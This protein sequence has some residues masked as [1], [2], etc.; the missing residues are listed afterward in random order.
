MNQVAEGSQLL[1]TTKDCL[2]F[3]TKC[4]EVISVSAPHIYHSAP[5]FRPLSSVVRK[6]YCH[7]CP[8]PCPRVVVGLPDVWDTS[9]AIPSM[10][11]SQGNILTWS[12][13]SQFIAAQAGRAVEICAPLTFELLSTL[14]PTES[15]IALILHANFT[16]FY[17]P[18]RQYL[19]SNPLSTSSRLSRQS[20]N[21][22]RTH[23]FLGHTTNVY[24]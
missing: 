8:N 7:Q 19:L 9:I 13:Y 11:R 5:E 12:P 4:F 14:Q 16:P 3:V 18:T 6:L 10:A 17:R 15:V 23:S 20:Q 22:R 2:H 21:T 1:E 24:D